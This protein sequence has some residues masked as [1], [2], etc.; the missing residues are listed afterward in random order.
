MMMMMIK[1]YPPKIT[2]FP[3]HQAGTEEGDTNS[4]DTIIEPWTPQQLK[5]SIPA[6]LTLL[7]DPLLSVV[8]TAYVTRLGTT[9]LA[10]LGSVTSIF[11]LAFNT[12]RATTL[13]TTSLVGPYHA[14]ATE[15]G[16]QAV[17][18][19]DLQAVT[20]LSL[21]FGSLFGF[22]V[23]LFLLLCGKQ[24]L[25][26]MGIPQTS[27]LYPHAASYLHTRAW[28]APAVA[29][30]TV[31]TGLFRGAGTTVMPLIS[32]LIASGLNLILD[33][34]L[35][36]GKVAWGI[37]GAAAA[38]AYSQAAAAIVLAVALLRTRL[39]TLTKSVPLPI[40]KRRLVWTTIFKANASMMA[41]QGSLLTAW[42]FCTAQATRLGPAHVAAHQVAL[43]VWLVVA[44]M[45]DSNAVGA[46][47]LASRYFRPRAH[48]QSAT[49]FSLLRYQ[50][51]LAIGQG[52][53]ATVLIATILA[54]LVPA[55]MGTDKMV[56]YHL[57]QLLPTLALQ[58]ILVSCTMVTEALAAA[59]QQFTFLAVGTVLAT[60]LS[61]W[62]LQTPTSVTGLWNKG[63]VTLFLGRWV[64]A[65]LALWS[66]L[67]VKKRET[68]SNQAMD[69]T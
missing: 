37:K 10:S 4:D 35:M 8:D 15:M 48:R 30:T 65:S 56:Q 68:T 28:A 7:S 53:G 3:I 18:N 27:E 41:K 36:F 19:T 57:Q 11:H 50:A 47:I 66:A 2:S 13:A 1:R 38:T 60:V 64:T 67:R 61:I 40:D 16:Q 17:D 52:V 43:S 42:A 31:A 24:I 23:G 62:Q 29:F 34:L 26:T 25:A 20:R 59:T 12:F 44:L 69:K 5:L 6:M 21:Q 32:S 58:Q 63:I 55:T 14:N 54:P 46:Q 51:K 45:L 39:V 49:F 9:A 22:I 33:P